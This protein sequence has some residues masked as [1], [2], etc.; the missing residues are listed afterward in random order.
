MDNKYSWV[1][2]NKKGMIKEDLDSA[3]IRVLGWEGL[4]K[5]R[6][7]KVLNNVKEFQKF[8]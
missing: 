6:S 1:F 7:H 8:N 3:E 5:C 4:K 2:D